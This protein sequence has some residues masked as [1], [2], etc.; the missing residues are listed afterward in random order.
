MGTYVVVVV[1]AVVVEAATA[2]THGA[3]NKVGS[4][5]ESPGP[6]ARSRTERRLPMTV[7]LKTRLFAWVSEQFLIQPYTDLVRYTMP[8]SKSFAWLA[9]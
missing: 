8:M 4:G 1:V 7:K 5:G 2:S 3:Q 6:S 9:L